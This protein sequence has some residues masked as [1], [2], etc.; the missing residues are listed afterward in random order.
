MKAL[1]C[2]FSG[3]LA[4]ITVPI[5]CVAVLN[6]GLS[7]AFSS[8]ETYR[9]AFISDNSFEQL[10]P[11][12]LPFLLRNLNIDNLQVGYAVVEL[13]DFNSIMTLE[14]WREISTD[15]IPIQWL[16][17][18]Y[19]QLAGVFGD[20]LR[21]R[22]EVIDNVIDVTVIRQ[23]LSGEN[24]SG[25]ADSILR[26]APTCTQTQIDQLRSID[27]ETEATFPFCS[28]PENLRE[29]SHETLVDWM[30]EI[31]NVM[32][33]DTLPISQFADRNG[34]EALALFSEINNQTLV[35]LYLCPVGII[36]LIV[37]MSV[38]NFR[39]FVRW[40]GT[41]TFT[42]GLLLIL[43]VVLFQ[44]AILGITTAAFTSG[45]ADPDLISQFIFSIVISAFTNGLFTTFFQAG[46]L[47]MIGFG[48]FVSLAFRRN[49]QRFNVGETVLITEDGR[50][51][52]TATKPLEPPK[53]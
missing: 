11:N 50:I 53:S 25:I 30:V 51:I 18:T 46:C 34:A 23:N 47:V 42:T 43:F 36:G 29:L 7:N 33:G 20:V 45:Q 39:T 35:I 44:F 21:G 13:K 22:I 31:S 14:N 49:T 17:D 48:L 6:F 24:A 37:A 5:L 40:T 26:I 16:R 12:T 3:I 28:P 2:F 4:F 38:R 32:G 1:G 52:S 9:N 19:N 10:I 8:P 15:I 27:S 41:I